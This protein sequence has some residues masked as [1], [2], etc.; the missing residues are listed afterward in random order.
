MVATEVIPT[1]LRPP[2]V[3]RR[4]STPRVLEMLSQARSESPGWTRAAVS[5]ARMTFPAALIF[6]ESLATF[7]KA[8]TLATSSSLAWGVRMKPRLFPQ[9]RDPTTELPANVPRKGASPRCLSRAAIAPGPVS[10][11]TKSAVSVQRAKTPSRALP[12]TFSRLSDP[13]ACKLSL[14]STVVELGRLHPH[15]RR[16]FL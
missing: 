15:P 11:A 5:L 8:E 9:A 12:A 4:T 2:I 13:F 10:G 7:P 14:N 1:V 16:R 6:P 3:P